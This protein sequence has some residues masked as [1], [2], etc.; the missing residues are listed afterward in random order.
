[1]KHLSIVEISH[2]IGGISDKEICLALLEM[3][4][5]EED[6]NSWSDSMVETWIEMYDHY[7]CYEH[8][9]MPI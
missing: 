8:N 4:Q 3:V 2:L 5:D 6:V 1:M 7:S 9:N